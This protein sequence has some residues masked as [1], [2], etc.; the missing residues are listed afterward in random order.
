[1]LSVLTV[2]YNRNV[3]ENGANVVWRDPTIVVEVVPRT[4]LGIKV[5]VH[6]E[7]ERKQRLEVR[8][9][10]FKKCNTEFAEG[11]RFVLVAVHDGKEA[12][13]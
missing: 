8:A 4:A 6:F 3:V 7:C 1:M 13:R 5:A 2:W 9:V 11:D 12:V 10:Y